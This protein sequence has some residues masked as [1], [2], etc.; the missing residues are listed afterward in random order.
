[1]WRERIAGGDSCSAP[2]STDD[3]EAAAWWPDSAG[4]RLGADPLRRGGETGGGDE[5]A[6]PWRGGEPLDGVPELDTDATSAEARP[7]VL[8]F[9]DAW[10]VLMVELRRHRR[11]LRPLAVEAMLTESESRTRSGERNC[12][13]GDSGNVDGLPA[14][15][16]NEREAGVGVGTVE[17]GDVRNSLAPEMGSPGPGG[18]MVRP[19]PAPLA[20]GKVWAW[21]SPTWCGLGKTDAATWGA[22]GAAGRGGATGS[23][24]A[25]RE[26]ERERETTLRT[27]SRRLPVDEDGVRGRDLP[28]TLRDLSDVGVGV[29]I[30][31]T[32]SGS[33]AEERSRLAKKGGRL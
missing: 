17:V 23:A 12:A 33:T 25:V 1:M 2:E 18:T 14:A 3:C 15:I 22:T 7:T 30:P 20:C 4:E 11:R 32:V 5:P 28:L 8:G 19:A 29:G 9:G 24:W 10:A 13:A 26:R 16:V 21:V 6:L 31:L 27:R